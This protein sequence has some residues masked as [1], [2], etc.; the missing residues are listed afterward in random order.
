MVQVEETD[1]TGTTHIAAV[2]GE[3]SFF[4]EA[5]LLDETRRTAGVRARTRT[6]LLCLRRDDLDQ[7]ASRCPA[8]VRTIRER[9]KTFQHLLRIPIFSDLPTNLLRSIL[10]RVEERRAMPREAIVREGDDGR[11]LYLITAGAFEV[12]REENGRDEKVGELY[13]G[14]YFGEIALIENVP[15]TATVRARSTGTLLVVSADDFLRLL[16]GSR[17]FAVNLHDLGDRRLEQ[18]SRRHG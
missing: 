14:D 9:L 13:A 2:L 5:A 4:G 1:L 15:R 16:S 8:A 11:E 10:P 12:V 7:F 3:G 6:M 17:N 18:N